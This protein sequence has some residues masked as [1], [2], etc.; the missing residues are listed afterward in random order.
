[1]RSG[2][3][4]RSPGAPPAGRLRSAARRALSSLWWAP[5]GA[6]ALA[7]RADGET[8]RLSCAEAVGREAWR[9]AL[10]VCAA[11]LQRTSDPHAALGL[12]VARYETGDLPGCRA[13][14]GPLLEGEGPLAAD[15]NQLFGRALRE[16]DG[17]LDLA[18]RHI[19]RAMQLHEAH[20]RTFDLAR[21]VQI[22]AGFSRDRG[23]YHEALSRLERA[24]R[25][26]ERAGN[27]RVLFYA[28]FGRADVL[29]T[30]G[31]DEQ[32]ERELTAALR[33][34]ADSHERS[35]ALLKLGL[36]HVNGGA[37]ALAKPY[38]RQALELAA[39]R[40]ERQV[41]VAAR[42]NLAWVARREGKLDEAEALL[43][44]VPADDDPA[45]LAFN[46]AQIANDRGDRA[47]AAAEFERAERAALADQN[48]DWAWVV[49][50]YAGEL[51][52]RRK[53]PA[54]AEAAYRRAIAAV[55]RLRDNAGQRL[56]AH[57]LAG[58]RL[59]YE[60]L[61]GLLGSAGRFRDLLDVVRSLDLG[62]VLATDASEIGSDGSPI[63]SR[64]TRPALMPLAL[65]GGVA[66]GAPGRP[67]LDAVIEAWRGR[68]LVA[69]MPGR[70]RVFRVEV[71][72]GEVRGAD[73]GA[74]D[75]LERLADRL[76]KDAGDVE[77]ARALGEAMV[78]PGWGGK[79]VDLL[80][81]GPL[82]RVP[83]AALRHGDAL[84]VASTPL[85]R[86]LGLETLRAPSRSG[87]GRVVVGD[88]R[89]DLPSAADEARWVA[90]RLGT[91]ARLG[92]E[93]TRGALAASR[94]ADLLH[95][96]AHAVE[97]AEGAALRL[98]DRDLAAHEIATL[99]PAAR[100]VVLASCASAASRD[101]TGWG[102][103]AA[104]FVVAGAEAVV[105]T[106]W[107]VDDGD[108]TRV[109]KALYEDV[110][111]A[112][113]DPARALAAAQARLAG[114][115]PARAWAAFTVVRAPPAVVGPE[116]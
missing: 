54:A 29:R 27:R 81:V 26:A 114:D 18:E 99:T 14:V 56:A 31:D 90:G 78:P 83:L 72:G 28:A 52:E 84:V 71:E 75:D 89:G 58:R 85:A 23:E 62:A 36:L 41:A 51:E 2:S 63:R 42:M 7:L 22:L 92:G 65:Q 34:A 101:G 8:P 48:D 12:G 45:A 43:A 73:V 79:A 6:L 69:L 44:S 107:S 15:A 64:G 80:V 21:D 53:S 77:A 91:P 30:A 55:A 95:V 39:E 102:S 109:V 4:S 116:E 98:A 97:G 1:V 38:L 49:A 17:D 32:A 61:A 40:A 35:W 82:G 110:P 112:L 57:V 33:K 93:V 60:G 103:L 13:I 115:L 50:S 11:E 68:R 20:G 104:A 94:D 105:A 37:D 59:P 87:R 106:Q 3:G 113:G 74:R 19:D 88:P 76:E 100:V 70:E 96:A 47:R 108:A 46:R 67:G 111:R 86:V 10:E 5:A 16:G 25:L 9:Q 66:A 24:G